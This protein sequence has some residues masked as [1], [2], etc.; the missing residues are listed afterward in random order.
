MAALHLHRILQVFTADTAGLLRLVLLYCL[1][2]PFPVL[3]LGKLRVVDPSPSL[4]L[5]LLEI[6][7]QLPAGLVVRSIVQIEAAVAKR[8]VARVMPVLAQILHIVESAAILNCGIYTRRAHFFLIGLLRI[9]NIVVGEL[10]IGIVVHSPVHPC[11]QLPLLYQFGCLHV[12]QKLLF[13]YL[14]LKLVSSKLQIFDQILACL[15]VDAF[16]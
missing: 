7:F 13:R 10:V 6:F 15:V 16:E 8:T 11:I 12:I 4:L 1:Q 2:Q 5:G 9:F 14:L 3:L